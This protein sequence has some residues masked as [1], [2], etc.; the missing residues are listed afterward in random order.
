MLPKGREPDTA[1]PPVERWHDREAA[2]YDARYRDIPYWRLYNELTWRTIESCLPSRPGAAVLDAGGGTGLWTVKLAERGYKVT[3]VDISAGMLEVAKQ[4]VAD[5]G[6]SSLVD[7]RKMD[8]CQMDELPD[9]RYALVI[10]EGDVLSYCADPDKAV[11]GFQRVAR[12]G[13]YVL[14]S[15]D[16]KLTTVARFVREGDLES[17]DTFLETGIV[18]EQGGVEAENE[19]DFPI[20]PF[21]PWELRDI[22]ERHGL[23]TVRVLGKPVYAGSAANVLESPRGYERLVELETESNARPE[24]LGLA[25]HIEIVARKP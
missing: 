10:A 18:Y 2:R 8:V 19:S 6:L 12:S 24:L 13:A 21:A 17:L 20:R 25:P 11:A 5:K 16:N 9:D 15:V 23:V 22:F 7:I 1:P 4:K 3:L 14:A